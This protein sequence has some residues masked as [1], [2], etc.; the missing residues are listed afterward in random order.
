[1]KPTFWVHAMKNKGMSTNENGAVTVV[2]V[3]MLVLLTIIGVS[4]TKTS[5]IELLI[6]GNDRVYRENLYNAESAGLHAAQIMEN[7]DLT[8]T[9]LAWVKPDTYPFDENTDIR[10]PNYW[11]NANSQSSF[12]Q[13]TRF[14]AVS[15]GVVSGDSLDMEVSNVHNYVIY[16]R[17]TQKDGLAFV[18]LGYRKPF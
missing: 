10:D 17:S 2:A 15:Q 11:V 1:M 14:S 3:M 4:V 18:K 9:T 5:E 6:A 8:T 7:T 13:N 12:A 16:G